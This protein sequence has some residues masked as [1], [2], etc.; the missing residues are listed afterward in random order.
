MHTLIRFHTR[1]RRNGHERLSNG[2]L[3]TQCLLPADTALGRRSYVLRV[4]P[5]RRVFPDVVDRVADDYLEDV[6][7]TVRVLDGVDR[8]CGGTSTPAAAPC[9]DRTLGS[10]GDLHVRNT[11]QIDLLF[12][13]RNKIFNLLSKIEVQNITTQIDILLNRDDGENTIFD[14]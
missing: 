13:E 3:P 9:T 10:F 1:L 4:F 8:R 14:L 5:A 6:R 11:A 12:D 7:I 2:R